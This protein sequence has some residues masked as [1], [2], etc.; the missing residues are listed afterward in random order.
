MAT[1]LKTLADYLR[2]RVPKDVPR[3]SVEEFRPPVPPVMYDRPQYDV[4]SRLDKVTPPNPHHPAEA[5]AGI[6][7]GY[8]SAGCF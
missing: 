1:K 6:E 4:F 5:G 7:F 8:G 3:P 2:W